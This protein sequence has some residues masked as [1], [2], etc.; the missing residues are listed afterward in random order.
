VCAFLGR[1]DLSCVPVHCGRLLPSFGCAAPLPT[2][3]GDLA[4]PV[5][6]RRIRETSWPT[7]R[8]SIHCPRVP[9]RCALTAELA[10]RWPLAAALYYAPVYRPLPTTVL[11][12]EPRA[13]KWAAH[14]SCPE[15]PAGRLIAGKPAAMSPLFQPPQLATGSSSHRLSSPKRKSPSTPTPRSICWIHRA[16]LSLVGAAA[17]MC[18]AAANPPLL[19]SESPV[20]S[21]PLHLGVAEP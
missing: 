18:H 14:N 13:Y 2:P 7:A 19:V 9:N 20:P 6:A 11:P 16:C 10:R 17:R 4:S 5:Q 15:P 12:I 8:S 3:R 21:R 1:V